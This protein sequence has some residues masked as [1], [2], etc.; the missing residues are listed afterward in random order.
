MPEIAEELTHNHIGFAVGYRSNQPVCCVVWSKFLEHSNIP[1][2]TKKMADKLNKKGF[3]DQ[4]FINC[5]QPNSSEAPEAVQEKQLVDFTKKVNAKLE[6]K[7]LVYTKLLDGVSQ[8]TETHFKLVSAEFHQ[9]GNVVVKDSDVMSHKLAKCR[10]V[11]DE[12]GNFQG[13]A[14]EFEPWL[15]PNKIE[16]RPVF[17]P[18]QTD[19]NSNMLRA[20]VLY[21]GE[22]AACS[23]Y[24]RR[25][26]WLERIATTEKYKHGGFG[27]YLLLKLEE[28]LLRDKKEGDEVKILLDVSLRNL[29]VAHKFYKS[30]GFRAHNPRSPN[31][32]IKTL[33]A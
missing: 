27:T 19:D 23:I 2:S 13:N 7:K 31:R 11:L 20:M 1:E 24:D 26:S 15:A 33:E 30:L 4:K 32:L 12:D 10:D 16:F 3:L 22:V 29:E 28:Q 21:N 14:L 17:A 5:I 8:R 6:N 9:A 25:Y 18:D